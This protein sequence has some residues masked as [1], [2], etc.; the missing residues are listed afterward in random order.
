MRK[1]IAVNNSIIEI[2]DFFWNSSDSLNRLHL[3]SLD[4]MN[5][6]AEIESRMFDSK[7]YPVMS[8]SNFKYLLKKGNALLVVLKEQEEIA[9]YALINFRKNSTKAHFG[10]LAIDNSYQK[11]GFGNILFEGVERISKQ[12]GA[13]I[14]ILE[15]REDNQVLL[16]RYFRKGYKVILKDE[17]FYADGCSAIR[18]QKIL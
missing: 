3:A 7:S 1:L 15:I 16:S 4:D 13:R 11:M 10:S 9:G 5:S 2:D 12:A 8:V 6:L 14:L 18:M 17:N